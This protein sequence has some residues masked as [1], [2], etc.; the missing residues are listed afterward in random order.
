MAYSVGI[1]H[2]VADFL[3]FLP[4]SHRLNLIMVQRPHVPKFGAW[5]SNGGNGAAYTAV[6]DSARGGGKGGKPI[7]PND[8]SE[9]A[10]QMYGGSGAPQRHNERP[11]PRARPAPNDHGK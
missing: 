6:F 1:L 4:C 5:D 9:N 2:T 3:V 10:G 7:N 11:P 8:P